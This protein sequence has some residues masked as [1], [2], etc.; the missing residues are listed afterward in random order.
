M[1]IKFLSFITSFLFISLIV[2]SCLDDDKVTIES[3]SDATIYSFSIN[4]IKT[5][6]IEKN[7]TTTFTIEGTDYKF[8]IDQKQGIIYNADSLPFKT[9]VSKVVV[10]ITDAG[11]PIYY[12]TDKG[13]SLWF[14]TDSLDFTKAVS[15]ETAIPFTVYALDG[16]TKKSY[17]VWMNV[18]KADPDSLKWNKINACQFP[19]TS[20]LGRQKAIFYENK[21]YVFAE[22]DLQV[23]VTFTGMNDGKEWSSLSELQGITTGK[24][25]YSSVI[26]FNNQLYITDEKGYIYNS[27]NGIDWKS[28]P[29]N[30]ENISTFV[31]SFTNS[32]VVSTRLYS[33]DKRLIGIKGEK[34]IQTADGMSWEEYEKIPNNFSVTNFVSTPAYLTATNPDIERVTIGGFTVVDTATVIWSILSNE[35]SCVQISPENNNSYVCPKL[36][37]IAI[38]HYNDSLYAFGGKEI[39]KEN[40]LKAFQTFYCSPDKGLTWKP[41]SKKMAFPA[42]FL[43]KSNDFSYVIDSNQYIWMMWSGENEVWKGR[44]NK[45]GFAKQ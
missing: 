34:F 9:D 45:L 25:N 2:S 23:K 8:S 32:P 16:V 20:I 14:S 37:N 42:S 3:S 27:S 41:S 17:K 10:N 4:N 39:N 12:Q 30:M 18:H 40:G 22:N 38:I 43:G 26:V 35:R 24:A 28:V 33:E 7:D 29:T 13:D 21:I 15:L 31:A 1:R 44:I 5:T 36:E 19:G 11:G 6:I